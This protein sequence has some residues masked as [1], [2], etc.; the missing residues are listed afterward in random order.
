M[1]PTVKQLKYLIAL[2]EQ[3]H[4]GRAAKAC[5]ISQ[6][7]FS[8]AIKELESTL[9][10]QLIERSNKSVMM[11]SAGSAVVRQARLCM[12]DIEVL[13]EV[14]RSEQQALSGRL[15][16]GVIPTIA[17][18][19]LP[20]FVSAL[21][22]RFPGLQLYLREDK[23]AV[24]YEQLQ[25]GKLDL[26]LLAL[27]FE[28]KQASVMRLFRDPFLLACCKQSKWVRCGDA[29]T[30]VDSLPEESV[31]LLEDGHCLRDHALS[32]CHLSGSQKISRFAA[33]SLSTLLQMVAADLGVTFV[34]EMARESLDA[35][36]SGL[37]LHPLP[38]GFRDIGLAWRK[39]S[40]REEEFR[41]LGEL[42]LELHGA[43]AA[44]RQSSLEKPIEEI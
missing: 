7:A 11:T 37:E 35:A 19:L 29:C 21:R 26:I 2:D 9:G 31:L 24:L 16:M 5:F 43:A 13:A 18:Y 44:S 17:P 22:H 8:I 12:R 1:L 28:L 41:Q 6:S 40:Y 33:T 4:F 27:P 20:S 32:A 3:R 39:G 34:P 25:E 14:A 30:G 15:T 10:V 42:L 36:Q 38:D 23:S